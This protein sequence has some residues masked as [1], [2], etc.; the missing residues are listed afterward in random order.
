MCAA[1]N[2]DSLPAKVYDMVDFLGVAKNC[3][4]NDDKFRKLIAGED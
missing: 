1:L 2:N 3:H 4:G